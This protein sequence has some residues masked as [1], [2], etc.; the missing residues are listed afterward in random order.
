MIFLVYLQLERLI[1]LK[2]FCESV[3][4]DRVIREYSL[5]DS[6]WQSIQDIVST[7]RPFSKY[8]TKLQSD[9]ST[10]S[11]FFGYWTLLRIKVS[12][13]ASTDSLCSSI[14]HQMNR[15][16]DTLMEN[17]LIIAAMFLDPRHQR[18]LM[19]RKTLA[20]EY[21][22]NLH[23][24]IGKIEAKASDEGV[25]D[26]VQGSDGDSF[27]ELEEYLS[28]CASIG[29]NNRLPVMV[30]ESQNNVR[31]ALED[32]CG[33]KMPLNMAI[34][35]FWEKNKQEMALL[36]KLA[37]VVFGVPPTQAS[38]ER[39][40]SALALII[41]PRRTSLGDETMQNILLLRLNTR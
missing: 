7:L 27:E 13:S 3:Q 14:L 17:P 35:E 9:E 41:T 4:N 24:K 10:L 26:V 15:Y 31:K 2:P 16:H 22:C 23:E 29:E 19:D 37:T 8:T 11:D 33:V 5:T 40:F 36:Y 20:I 39:A 21:L 6:E 28:A 25:E 32:F 1:V 34:L 38:V 30:D 12:K 18:G